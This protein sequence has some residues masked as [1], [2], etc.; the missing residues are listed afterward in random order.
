VP[1]FAQLA[2]VLVFAGLGFK[3]AAVPFHFYAPDVY[4]GT[5]HVNAGVLAVLPKI[6]GITALVRIVSIAMPGV[7]ET[8]VRVA[9]ILALV[10]MTLGNVTALWQDDLRRMFAYSSIAH[11]GYMLVGL[12]VDFAAST[13]AARESGLEV[14]GI[15]AAL[16]YVGVYSVATAGT[17]AALAYLGGKTKQID[18]VDDL[19]GIARSQPAVALCVAI[20]MFSLT[21][22]PPLAGFWGKLSLFSGAVKV[23]MEA[24]S[25]KLAG[26]F[27]VLAVVGV[28]NA[29]V[30]AAYY[31]RIIG[32][33]YFRDAGPAPAPAEGGLGAKLAT[34]ACGLLVLGIGLGPRS[35]AGFSDD[36]AKS[37]RSEAPAAHAAAP[38]APTAAPSPSQ[39]ASR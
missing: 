4:Q 20:F 25:V 32:A 8:A 29:A 37:A 24:G 31:L 27:L 9:L 3:I 2:L 21:G 28:L 10:T 19:A 7:E 39:H 11:A 18:T 5:T 34:L 16:F 33:M 38:T 30:S 13:P 22:L 23:G 1:V 12:A 36:A 14:E 15:G 6:A 17:F 26:W 35:L